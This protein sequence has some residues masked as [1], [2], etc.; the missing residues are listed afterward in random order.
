VKYLF[1]NS[2]CGIRSTG[3]ICIDLAEKLEREGHECKIAYGRGEVPEQYK[4]YAVRIG[5]DIDVKMHVIKTRLFDEHGFGSK[6]ATKKFI[7]WVELYNPD[8]IWLH[9]IH[10]YYINVEILF[11]WIKKNPNLQVKW[12]LHDC[13][14]FTGHCA[15]FTAINCN[16]WNSNNG[17]ISCPQLKKYPAC[18]MHSDVKKNLRRKYVAFSG[19]KNLSLVTPSK[20]LES[21]VKKSFLKDYSI[22]VVYNTVDRNIFKPT[23]SNFKEI[24]G[25]KGKIMVLGVASVWDDRKGLKDFVTLSK[26]LDNKYQIVLVGLNNK[27][28][29]RMPQNII[30]ISRTNNTKQLAEIYSAADVFVNP[31]YEDNYPTVNLESQY[32]GT[33]VYA[34]NTGG[35]IETIDQN[36]GSKIIRVGDINQLLK[37]I[38]QEGNNEN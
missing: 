29:N 18:Y 25:L 12:T 19:V 7:K 15:Y 24:N 1:I 23:V 30:C 8:V 32:C 10:G 38:K 22:E 5:N 11:A 26:L 16:Q 6:S 31:T 21:L 9:N 34:Y 4:K 13:W 35:T 17:C 27:Q 20:W 14:A 37:L 3:R 2:V 33:K 36:V 28:I